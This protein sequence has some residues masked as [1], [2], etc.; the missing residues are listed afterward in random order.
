MFILVSCLLIDDANVLADVPESQKPEVE[1]LLE[2]IETSACAFERNG[3]KYDGKEASKHIKRKYKHFRDQI[4]NTEEFIEYSGT[5]ST[6]SGN[7]Y[8]IY[9]DGNNPIKSQD[10]LLEELTQFRNKAP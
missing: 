3:K 7:F 6:M 4:T 9:C 2:F 10:W 8:L 5:K 1:Y